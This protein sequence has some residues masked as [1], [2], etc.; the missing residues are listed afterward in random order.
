MYA[1]K[2]AK[3]TMTPATRKTATPVPGLLVVVAADVGAVDVGAGD[4]GAAREIFKVM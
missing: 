2:A 3:A 4:V 1:A